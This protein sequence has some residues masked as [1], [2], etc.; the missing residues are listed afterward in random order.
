MDL[1]RLPTDSQ[2]SRR[3]GSTC[4]CLTCTSLLEGRDHIHDWWRSQSRVE[5]WRC[6]FEAAVQ[7]FHANDENSWSNVTKPLEGNVDVS[8]ILFLNKIWTIISLTKMPLGGGKF[9]KDSQLNRGVRH[10]KKM[11]FKWMGRIWWQQKEFILVLLWDQWK[12]WRKPRST[13]TRW[14]YMTMRLAFLFSSSPSRKFEL[15]P[16]PH[17]WRRRR[18]D[19]YEYSV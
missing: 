4:R 6:W 13:R 5:C 2:Q 17:T 19:T 10:Q 15:L 14:S 12:T 8:P 16:L 3:D 1:K 18:S 9:P 11:N 7:A